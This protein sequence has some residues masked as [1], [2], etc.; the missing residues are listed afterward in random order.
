MKTASGEQSREGASKAPGAAPAAGGAAAEHPQLSGAAPR[1]WKVA[2]VDDEK[3]VHAVT[4][5]VLRDFRFKN[6]PL[7]ILSEYSGAGAKR[8]MREHPDIAV[9]VL[10]VVMEA[11]DA[12][13]GVVKYVREELNNS[14]VRIMLRTGQPGEAPEHQVIS[15]YD[16]NDYKEKSHLTASKLKSALTTALRT[17]D[18]LLGARRQGASGEALDEIVKRRTSELAADNDA[19]RSQM[20]DRMQVLEA[21]RRNEALLAEAQRIAGVGAFEWSVASGEIACSDQAR[22]ILGLAPRAA[23]RKL[24]DLLAA[25]PDEDR[26]RVR[27]ALRAALQ[28]NASYRFEHRVLRP[29]GAQRV[30][31]QQGEALGESAG[32]PQRVI[33]IVHDITERRGGNE[34]LRQLAAAIEQTADAVMITDRRGVIEYV[35]AAFTRMTGFA[36][37]EALGQTP[38]IL[39]SEKQPEILYR[40]MWNA[41]LR[42]EVFSDVFVNRRKDG[43]AYYEAKTVTPQRN[44]AGEVTHFISTGRDVTESMLIQGRVEQHAHQDALTGLPNR[45]LLADRL[46]QALARARWTKRHVAVLLLDVDRFKAVNDNYG[47]DVGDLLLRGVAQ[48]LTGCVRDGDTVARLGGD[49]FAVIL[50]DVASRDDVAQLAH[51]I[52]DS[53]RDA[54]TVG[55]RELSVTAS[56][57]VSLYP[58]DGDTGPLLLKRADAALY[59]AKAGGRNGYQF[60]T[61]HEAK[62]L[63]KRGVEAQLKRALERDEF[64]LAYQ[65]QVDLSS[66]AIRGM[67]ALVR[68]RRPSGQIVAP[69]E[70]IPLLEETGMIVEVGEWVLRNACQAMRALRDAGEAPG[71]IAVNISLREIRQAGFAG[72]VEQAL[73]ESD[74]APELLELELS[75]AV[76]GEDVRSTV[77]TLEALHALGVRLAVDGFGAG[78]SSIHYLRRLPFDALK[79]DRSFVREVPADGEDAAIVKAIISVAHSIDLE[80]VAEGIERDDQLRF[81]GDLGCHAAQGHLFSAPLPA[82]LVGPFL[83][84]ASFPGCRYPRR[85]SAKAREA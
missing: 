30:V 75:E 41:I 70:F 35:N 26:A 48:R 40:R 46:E 60:Y 51:K 18:D 8:L 78:Y 83:R 4:R 21:L 42:G 23:P 13:L 28:P 9:L 68:W 17:Y 76:L 57:G 11:G 54:F 77:A 33:G 16:I 39:K 55:G 5:L 69:L 14:L 19:L 36:R 49:E 2:V 80:T 34:D 27:A 64:L 38:R 62:T 65:P 32:K 81:V 10:D 44:E 12:G 79:I 50:N 22:S 53:M 71:R 67:E 73:D 7:E 1:P 85:P 56:I 25:V 59:R 20:E 61:E 15:D 84:S 24:D 63:K 43:S 52:F 29:D 72:R 31:L 66:G 74:L 82:P 6:R 3:A 58:G 37:Q 47:H 45:V